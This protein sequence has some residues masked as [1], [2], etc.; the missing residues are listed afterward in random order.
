VNARIFALRKLRSNANI[1]HRA[2]SGLGTGIVMIWKK[3][4]LRFLLVSPVTGSLR[5]LINEIKKNNGIQWDGE[6]SQ[7]E[8][9]YGEIN[10]LVKKSESGIIKKKINKN[11]RLIG[12]YLCNTS[13]V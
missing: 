11:E 8:K 7:N 13:Y 6:K 10:S 9:K 2:F 12:S 5:K 4:Q 1:F 3:V